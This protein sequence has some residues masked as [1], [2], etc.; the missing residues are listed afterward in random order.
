MKIVVIDGQGGRIGAAVVEGLIKRAVDCELLAVGANSMATAAMMK[1]GAPDGASGENPVLVAC[2]S[3]DL[4]IGPL[5]IIAANSLHGEIT[6]KMALAIS[7]SPAH[8]I[9]IP[10]SRCK[11]AVAGTGSL[12]LSECISLAVDAAADYIKAN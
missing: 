3:A 5:G 9:L 10:V 8:K 2:A 1:A 12:S 7:E 6:P 4:I 11:I